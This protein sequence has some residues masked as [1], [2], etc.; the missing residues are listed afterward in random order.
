MESAATSGLKTKGNKTPAASGNAKMLYATAHQ[1]FWCILRHVACDNSIAATTSYGSPAWNF[2]KLGNLSAQNPPCFKSKGVE[3][4]I[5]TNSGTIGGILGAHAQLPQM[6]LWG[7]SPSLPVLCQ[8]LVS[9][10]QFEQFFVDGLLPN[11]MKCAIQL[12]EDS[13]DVLLRTLHCRQSTRV[14]AG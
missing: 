14:L 4:S 8:R 7:T 12:G 2:R 10:D 3:W 6:A 11:T 13:L 5:V 1:R 9:G